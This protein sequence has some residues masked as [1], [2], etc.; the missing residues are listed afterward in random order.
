MDGDASHLSTFTV[1]LIGSA[2]TVGAFAIYVALFGIVA[3]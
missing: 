3:R 2:A 1:F